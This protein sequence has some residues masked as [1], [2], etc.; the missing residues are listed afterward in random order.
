MAD[1]AIHCPTSVPPQPW[2][3]LVDPR[4]TLRRTPLLAGEALFAGATCYVAADGLAWLSVEVP[5][6]LP[7]GPA[8]TYAAFDGIC[9]DNVAA[10]EPV[11]LFGL[12]SVIDMIDA[13]IT[14]VAVG[15]F[16]WPSATPGTLET[17]DVSLFPVAGER[18][19]CKCLSLTTIEVIRTN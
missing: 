19:I 1:V 15:D 9:L 7:A 11:T 14:V 6:T 3:W 8:G 12:G 13:A 17:T 16:L 2:P 4:V 18:P 5:G 10:G